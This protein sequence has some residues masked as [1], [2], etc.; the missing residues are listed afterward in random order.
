[1]FIN[2]KSFCDKN[3]SN[4]V[5]DTQTTELQTPYDSRFEINPTLA[6]SISTIARNQ[7]FYLDFSYV[8]VISNYL[9]YCLDYTLSLFIYYDWL[10]YIIIITAQSFQ[11]FQKNIFFGRKYNFW[12]FFL[13]V[14]STILYLS[15]EILILIVKKSGVTELVNKL[16]HLRP[17]DKGVVAE[18]QTP[19]PHLLLL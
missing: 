15:G 18:G 10:L 17:A 1:M 13:Q 16:V 14:G 5:I 4:L 2:T 7:V 9:Y 12:N 3:H 6:R 19:R 11:L 8:F